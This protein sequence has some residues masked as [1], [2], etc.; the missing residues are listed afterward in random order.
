MD[1]ADVKIKNYAKVLINTWLTKYV[2]SIIKSNLYANTG[3]WWGIINDACMSLGS[4][5]LKFVS[6]LRKLLIT[7]F[8]KVN[9]ASE[10]G[11]HCLHKVQEFL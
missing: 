11:L 9:A 8:Y 4:L 1:G 5:F 10:Y 2:M 3:V 7:T 6:F